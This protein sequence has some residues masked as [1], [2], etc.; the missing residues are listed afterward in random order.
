MEK[1]CG[2]FVVGK[3]YFVNFLEFT[4]NNFWITFGLGLSFKNSGLDLHRQI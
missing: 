4:F 2:I 3:V 1:N